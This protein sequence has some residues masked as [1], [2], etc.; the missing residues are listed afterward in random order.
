MTVLVIEHLWYYAYII[1]NKLLEETRQDYVLFCKAKG[2]SRFRILCFS[3]MKNILPSLLVL[4]ATSAAHILG[5]TYV[6]ETV[7]S[8]PGLGQAAVT[9]G[10]GSDAPLLLGITV[11]SAF[12]VFSGN[13]AA[14]LLYAAVDPRIRRQ[15]RKGAGL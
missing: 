2:M 11:F 14:D 4:M 5:G 10:L 15:R 12:L 13:T 8:Y 7:F 3:C 1:R 6:V 9:A